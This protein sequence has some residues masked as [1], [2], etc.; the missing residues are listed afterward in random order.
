MTQSDRNET[1]LD[2]AETA[3]GL[4]RRHN[5]PTTPHVFE[6]FYTHF[7]GNNERVTAE[8]QPLIEGNSLS[9]AQILQI[10]E[11]HLSQNS[12]PLALTDVE[13]K[14]SIEIAKVFSNISEGM[15]SNNTLT[16]KLKDGIRDISQ[17]NSKEELRDIARQLVK[18]NQAALA[19]SSPSRPCA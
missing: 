14:L 9:E 13:E 3:M 7:E 12:D 17:S 10:Y 15:A 19:A 18:S 2:L 16:G 8:I 6:V 5:L 11:A 4:A 1:A